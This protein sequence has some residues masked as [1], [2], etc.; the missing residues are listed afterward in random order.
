MWKNN[1]EAA[2]LIKKNLTTFKE[3]ENIIDIQKSR[4]SY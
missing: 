3:G 4:S 1:D 2:E